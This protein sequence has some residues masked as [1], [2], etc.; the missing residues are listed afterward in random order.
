[1]V[2]AYP[3]QQQY[4]QHGYQHHHYT[5][6]DDH[7]LT[8]PYHFAYGVKDPHTH[9]FKSQYESSDGHGNVKGSYS[10]LEADGST[11]L[12]EYTAGDEGFNAVVKK[13]E[14]PNH[15]EN[16]LNNDDHHH[17]HHQQLYHDDNQLDQA[18]HHY[19]TDEQRLHHVNHYY[20]HEGQDDYYRSQTV[21]PSSQQYYKYY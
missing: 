13:I 10:L 19:Q 18:I 2:S 15:V 17:H 1:M 7:S 4:V 5:D 20:Q 21:A 14:S 3:P 11:R 16:K 8:G 9:D 6:D 12:V